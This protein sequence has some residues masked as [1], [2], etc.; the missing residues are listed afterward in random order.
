MKQ[1]RENAIVEES[2]KFN[3][4]LSPASVSTI[5]VLNC[6]THSQFCSGFGC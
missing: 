2:T 6:T 3:F 4:N 5:S 1:G